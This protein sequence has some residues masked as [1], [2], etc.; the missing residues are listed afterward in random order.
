MAAMITLKN[1]PCLDL[2]VR[3][4]ATLGANKA[5]GP[6]KPEKRLSALA[7]SSVLSN[8]LFKRH[9]SLKLYPVLHL[10]TS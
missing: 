1:V 9:A 4:I 10:N 6:A 7:L 3:A 2:A 8:K 5:S